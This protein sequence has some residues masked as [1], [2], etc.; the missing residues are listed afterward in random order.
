ML[1]EHCFVQGLS[2]P[3]L[4]VHVERDIRLYVH[5]DD[6][7]ADMPTHEEKWFA[8]VL[9]SK[10]DGMRTGKFH[11][12]GN[13]AMEVSFLNRVV[14]WDPAPGRAELEA[15]TRHVAMVL[16]D[17][18]IGQ[19]NTS[20]NSCC[21]ASEVRRTSIAGW[22]ETSERSGYHVER[23]SHDAR[24]LLVTDTSRLVIRCR[25]SST[26]DEESHDERPRGTQ[27]CWAPLAKAT[28]WSDRCSTTNIAWSSGGVLQCR[29][30]GSRSS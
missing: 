1:K 6:Y 10:Y 18:G 25:L 19:V 29:L 13:T 15:D 28:S 4:S 23:V 9:C 7:M 24:E 14:R 2:N 16:P 21:K 5:G 3:S 8:R 17:L 12:D 30:P 26:R 20:C 27:T 22:C 11:S